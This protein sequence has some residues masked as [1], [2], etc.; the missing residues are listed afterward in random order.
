M[1][2]ICEECGKKYRIDP[3]KMKGAEAK[4][5]CKAS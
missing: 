3:T 4:V 5:R 1:I 2:V